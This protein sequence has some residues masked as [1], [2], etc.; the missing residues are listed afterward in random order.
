M[1]PRSQ[2]NPLHGVLNSFQVGNN[3]ITTWDNTNL[4]RDITIFT[5]QKGYFLR[6][7][8][9]NLLHIVLI[10]SDYMPLLILL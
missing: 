3:Y 2:A 5:T 4:I 7:A 8:K 10:A 9:A 6:Y 1:V